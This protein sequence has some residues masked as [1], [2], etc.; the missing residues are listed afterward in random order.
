MS[1]RLVPLSLLFTTAAFA[2]TSTGSITGLVADASG[3][4]I[5]GARITVRNMATNATVNTAST[6]TGNFTAPSLP[7]GDYE[8]AVTAPGFKRAAAAHRSEEHTSELQSPM[9]LVCRLLLEKK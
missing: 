1:L 2:Q 4:A 5:A 8:I 6:A 9:Y 3:A 7:P